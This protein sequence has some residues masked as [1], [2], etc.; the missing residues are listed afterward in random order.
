MIIDSHVYC[1]EPADSARGYASS[2]EH[3]KWVQAAH[4]EHHQPAFRIGDRAPRDRR[5]SLLRRGAPRFRAQLP[6]CTGFA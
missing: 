3:L 5:M 1:F 6:G 4:A 2:E